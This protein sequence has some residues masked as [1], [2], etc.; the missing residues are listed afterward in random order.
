MIRK[1]I[2]FIAI[3]LKDKRSWENMKNGERLFHASRTEMLQYQDEKF[4]E[5]L[6]YAYNHTE[7]Y[8]E[9]FDEIGLIKNGDV[10][11]ECYKDI[12]ILTKEIIRQEGN[13][14]VS[15][16]AQ[17][18]G[19]YKNTSGG[20]TGEPVTFVQDRGYFSNNFADKLLFASL[21]GKKAGE[22]EVK[23]W[24]SERDILEGTIGFREKLINW[25]YNRIF[26]NSFVLTP[27]TMRSYLEEINKTKPKQIWTYAD[28]IFQLAKF[29][30]E[31]E[32]KMHSPKN[33]I[34][35]AGVL[36]EEMRSEITKAFP[37]TN[38]LDQYGSR[39][40]GVIGC[41]IGGKR[42]IRIFDHSVKVEICDINTG[43]V[44]SEGEGELL[45]SSLN[46]Y[47]MPLIRY[48]IGDVG[49][50]NDDLSNYEGSFSVLEKLTGRTNTHLKNRDGS[51]LHGEYA[52]HL[53]YNKKWIENFRVIQHSYED[54][55]FQIVLKEG[56]SEN[57]EQLTQM[58]EELKVVLPDCEV[59]VN[60]M[61]EI[62]KL[63]SGKYQ[64]VI[65]EIE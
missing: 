2:A 38:V 51:K 63:K 26:L 46:N 42:G 25:C 9:K 52:T 8:R 62:P 37:N 56:C 5:L 50:K 53:F 35:T 45:V 44:T 59:T 23:L 31:N 48:K 24:G 30:N 21:N 14:L 19:M 36:Y 22:K 57:A 17:K 49:K 34:S 43:N 1:M 47:S 29:A 33:I 41:E 13:R 64:F 55:E 15:D 11:R 39:E 27:E 12:P 10:D 20:S 65:C 60:Y 32:I 58:K 4:Q 18:R 54:I 6:L 3:N 61:D 16:E 40:A 28:S 7:Y